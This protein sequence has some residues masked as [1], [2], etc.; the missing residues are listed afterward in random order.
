MVDVVVFCSFE[1]GGYPASRRTR[2]LSGICIARMERFPITIPHGV[3]GTKTHADHDC[4]VLPETT[5]TAWSVKL[6]FVHMAE[7]HSMKQDHSLSAC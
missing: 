5:K 4:T 3:E 2:G 7:A 1:N 6:E